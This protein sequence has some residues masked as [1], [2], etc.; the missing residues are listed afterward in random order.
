MKE[1]RKKRI[2]DLRELNEIRNEAYE[3]SQINKATMKAFHDKNLRRREFYVHQKVWLYN[4]RLK[5]FPGKYKSRW[6]GPFI[7]DEIFDC[8]AIL[9]SNP[10]TGQQ[11]KVNGQRLKPYVENESLSP[12]ISL[13]QKEVR[14]H[15]HDPL[16]STT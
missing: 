5:L 2:L 9:L 16:N 14:H 1:D 11:M 10:K 4:S 13:N 3:T 15:G 8:G 7:I 6:D 12:V